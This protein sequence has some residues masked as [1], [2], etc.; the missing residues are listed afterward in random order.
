FF[1]A[2]QLKVFKELPADEINTRIHEMFVPKSP[3]PLAPQASENSVQQHRILLEILREK[4]FG[5][6]PTEEEAGPLNV[7]RVFSAEKNGICLGAFDFAS[8]PHVQ[9]RLYLAS[10]LN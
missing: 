5:G 9:L 1:E 8:Q 7:R 2:E 3:L 4:S 10:R 6:W